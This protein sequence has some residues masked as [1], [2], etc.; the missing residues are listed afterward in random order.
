MKALYVGQLSE[1]G[2]CLER[3]RTLARLGLECIPFDVVPYGKTGPRFERS[4]LYRSNMGR[5]ISRLNAALVRFG[6]SHRFDLVWVDKGTWIYPETVAA[7]RA[8]SERRFTIHY[9]PDPQI[10]FHRSRHF[11][12]AIPCYDL[13]VT[14]KSYELDL[15]RSHGAREIILVLQGYNS[16]FTPRTP[17][18]TEYAELNSDVCFIGHLERHYANKIRA[19]RVEGAKL[20]VWGPRWSRYARVRPS[21]RPIVQGDGIWGARYP[22][23]LSCSKIALGLISKW[24]PETTTTRT[25]EIPATG[26]FM[27]A[28]RNADHLALFEEGK[29][30]EFFA[31]DD[32]L[33]DKI[34][35]Y[36]TNEPS[37]VRIAAAGRERCVTS[38]YSDEHQLRKIIEYLPAREKIASPACSSG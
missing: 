30:A 21:L 25:F 33:R 14:T 16:R 35:F 17:R 19:A 8:K 12:A 2:T 23:A 7:L 11:L 15:Y 37:R 24:I 1:G 28:E 29:E 9:T 6:K 34:R 13:V 20:C 5:G 31:D 3:M 18:E 10:L 4:L 22:L 32:E 26:V 38:G 36:L 27:L